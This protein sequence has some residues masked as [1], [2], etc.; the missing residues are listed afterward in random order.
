MCLS[1]FVKLSVIILN[2]VV[3]TSTINHHQE[4]DKLKKEILRGEGEIISVTGNSTECKAKGRESYK[5]S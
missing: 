3:I 5:C 1:K 4:Y 2:I